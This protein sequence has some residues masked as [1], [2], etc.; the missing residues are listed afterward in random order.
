M[1]GKIDF[2][3]FA[4]ALTLHSGHILTPH[5]TS[6]EERDF[7]LNQV[8]FTSLYVVSFLFQW[9]VREILE[10]LSREEKIFLLLGTVNLLFILMEIPFLY[11]VIKVNWTYFSQ[12]EETEALKETEPRVYRVLLL[13]LLLFTVCLVIT[14]IVFLVYGF[15]VFQK[16]LS[17]NRE[18]FL[19]VPAENSER[20]FKNEEVV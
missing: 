12:E 4:R 20:L 15:K 18:V 7:E 5:Q 2:S 3:F 11:F 19:V 13:V 16:V 17:Y 8:E 6:A 1:R 14:S 9:N 10:S